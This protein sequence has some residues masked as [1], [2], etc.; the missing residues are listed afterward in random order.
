[1][2]E[3]PFQNFFG[4]K[5]GFTTYYEQKIA[6]DY[7]NVKYQTSNEFNEPPVVVITEPNVDLKRGFKIVKVKKIPVRGKATDKDGI[8][9]V[10]I[11]GVDAT[12]YEDGTFYMY[13][14]GG[15]DFL[16]CAVF[17]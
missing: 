8:Y 11:N 14:R 6:I 16:S 12:V 2:N 17:S 3:T 9:E 5:L 13:V 4:N 15:N 7:L 10:L 1:M